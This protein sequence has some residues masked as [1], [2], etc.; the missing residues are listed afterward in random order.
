MAEENTP[1]LAG[2]DM[3]SGMIT[4]KGI[5]SGIEASEGRTIGEMP[6]L[7]PDKI[8]ADLNIKPTKEVEEEVEEKEVKEDVED[9]SKGKESKEEIETKEHKDEVDNLE[10]E[11]LSDYEEDIVKFFNEKLSDSLKWDLDGDDAPKTVEELVDFMKEIVKEASEPTFASEEIKEL[12]KFVKEG[13]NLKDFYKNV[14]TDFLDTKSLDIENEYDQKRVIRQNL[15][16][17]GYSDERISRTIKRYEEA[18]VLEDEAKDALEIVEEY[19]KNSKQKLLENQEKFH[20]ESLEQQ[21]KFVSDVEKTIND[22]NLLGF[23]LTPAEQKTLM[24]YILKT[25]KNG[26]T[27]FQREYNN[28][29][30]TNLVR[31]AAIQ[32]Y[33]DKIL[34]K[35]VDKN[36]KRESSK[37]VKNLHDK[38]SQNKGNK[39]KSVG[40]Q[41]SA[42]ASSGLSFFSSMLR[43]E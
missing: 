15:K 37:A 26:L 14:F 8:K 23:E 28:N 32:K 19:E 42:E 30:A 4:G 38:L 21:Q 20:A 2:F 11:D 9:L 3:L 5:E 40:S 27:E 34:T 6:I 35:V 39:S 10:E 12:D 18:G 22:I 7:S 24:S 1:S 36:V 29:I 13:G 33:G 31:T 25:D 16:N 43:S 17:Q 41:N